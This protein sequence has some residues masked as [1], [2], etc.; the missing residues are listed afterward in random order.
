MSSPQKIAR[1]FFYVVGSGYAARACSVGITFLLRHRLAPEVFD[2]T[3]QGVLI[4]VMLSSLRDFGWLHSLLHFQDRVEEFVDTH[5]AL[6]LLISALV[7]LL[8]GG[9]GLG[10]YLYDPERYAWPAV[11]IWVF[12]GSYLLRSATQTSE[13]LLRMEF[14][15]GRLSLF[16]GLATVLA[17]GCA[18]GAAW[19]GWGRW[20]LVLGGWTTY[21]VFSAVYGLFYSAAVWCSRPLRL[22]PL[23]LDRDWAWRLL[24]YGKWFWLAWGV[25]F[26]FIWFYD[27]LV[28]SFFPGKVD[29]NSLAFYENAWWL[30]SIPTALVAHVIFAYTNTLY[31]RYQRDRERLSELFSAMMGLIFRVS[32]LA[33]LLLVFSARELTA[34]AGDGWAPAAPMIV[35]LAGY[36]FLRPLFDDGI[37]LLWAVGDTRRTAAILGVQAVV[38]LGLVPVMIGWM[39]VQGLAY[40][41]GVVAGIGALG[42]FVGLRAYVDLA[43]GRIFGAPVVALL[44]AGGA[45]NMYN[46]VRDG[47]QLADGAARGALIVFA[48]AGALGLLEWRRLI[49]RLVHLR[50]IMRGKEEEAEGQREA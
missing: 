39:G 27:K 26:N 22:W 17:L 9:V 20:S 10:L 14:E 23:R 3:F 11:V 46:W 31:S 34:L 7:C 12:S 42:V 5:F 45:G 21:A 44:V 40:S 48:Y 8:I 36:A 16:H 13:A 33:A 4:F 6:N 49:E 38:A 24:G 37:G 50:R 1:G 41:M 25:L 28:L 2:V 19:A 18:L 30:V 15:F 47:S 29:E 43:W 35:W 32:A